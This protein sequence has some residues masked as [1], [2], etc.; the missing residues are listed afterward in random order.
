MERTVK[1]YAKIN[2]TLDIT[3]K[4]ENGYHD[5]RTV[6]QTVDL[7]DLIT[8]T[9][10]PAS[11]NT[12]SVSCTNASD[13]PGIKWD[14]TNLVYKAADIV[15]SASGKKS[16]FYDVSVTVTKNIPSGAGMAGGSTDAAA[17]MNALNKMLG[18]PL[19]QEEL[20][21]EGT[22]L[23]ADIPFCLKGGTVLCEGIGEILTPLPAFAPYDIVIVK[24]EESLGTKEMYSL[25][26]S[27]K[28]VPH[29]A[30]DAAVKLIKEKNFEGTFS[31]LG[32]YFEPAAVNICPVISD[33]KKELKDAGADV[34]L[35]TGS[36]SV[37]FGIFK[38]KEKA[39]AFSTHKGEVRHCHIL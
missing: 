10:E 34:S 28:D 1:A 25:V 19:S 7:Y 4:R 22:K 32:N 31:V 6:M 16:L 38:D 26:D 14:S 17:V 8:I 3:G 20:Y 13:N 18:S 21:G 29:P 9:A 37:V 11:K 36:G 15:L 27:Y 23:G 39:A 33:I 12:I 30:V 2:L 5:I 35:M 24:P